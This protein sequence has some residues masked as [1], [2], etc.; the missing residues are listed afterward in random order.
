MLKVRHLFESGAYFNYRESTE[1]SI[2]RTLSCAT[3]RTNMY[4]SNYIKTREAHELVVVLFVKQH[5][6]HISLY[7]ALEQR[8]GVYL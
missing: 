6:F 4:T 8:L 2:E 3:E 7:Q 5:G 1:G